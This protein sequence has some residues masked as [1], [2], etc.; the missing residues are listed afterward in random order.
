MHLV[1]TSEQRTV[2]F[3]AFDEPVHDIG[4]CNMRV[5]VRLYK[6]RADPHVVVENDDDCSCRRRD[7]GVAGYSW[8]SVGLGHEREVERRT[9]G[10][11]RRNVMI[12][13]VVDHEYLHLG[14]V[15]R[16]E[17]LV[18][19]VDEQSTERFGPVVRRDDD[20]DLKTC[21]GRTGRA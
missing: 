16:C 10:Q 7:P 14:R 19:Q 2:S 9:S 12:A 15:Q 18:S 11:Y 8:S 4:T 1:I 5:K 13:A 21:A 3:V 20:R 6:A 17:R